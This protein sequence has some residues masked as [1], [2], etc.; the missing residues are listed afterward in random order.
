MKILLFANTD[1]YL[2]NF[3]L[4]LAQTLRG[5]GDEVVLVSPEGPYG[6]RLQALGFRWLPVPMTQRSLNPLTEL[7]TIF[8][9]LKLYQREK[10]D[11]VQHFTVKCILYGSLVCHLLGLRSIVNSVT[12]LGYVFM[13]GGGTRWWLR[14]PIKLFYRM[15]LRRTWVIFQNPDD[16]A[17]FLEVSSGGSRKSG[18]DPRLRCGH[19]ALFSAA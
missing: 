17:V 12:G 6:P 4:A 18:A 14:A 16:R 11:L 1:W 3:R 9:L 13:D 2:Y 10:P 15:V 7:Q 5:R 8:S 19:P